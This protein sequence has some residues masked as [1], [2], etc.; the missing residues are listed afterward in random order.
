MRTRR[1]EWNFSSK[2]SLIRAD[3]GF[4]TLELI[5][6][7]VIIAG[8]TAFSVPRIQN[9]TASYHLRQA[10]SNIV[11]QMQ[12]AR[13]QAI[14]NRVRMVVVFSPTAFTPGGGGSFFIYEDSSPKNWSPDPG[15]RVMLHSTSMPS[16]VTLTSAWFDFAGNGTDLR[17]YCGFD[18]QGLAARYGNIYVQGAGDGQGIVLRNSKNDT[19]TIRFWASGKAEIL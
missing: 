12:L 14:R 9:F 5:V 6:I 2:V 8:L 11:S 16:R 10:A 18:P 13:I 4:N 1:M 7:L 19:H 3:R 17:K 15:E